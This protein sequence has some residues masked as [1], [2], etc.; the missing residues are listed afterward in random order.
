M[1]PIKLSTKSNSLNSIVIWYLLLWR[2]IR[3]QK[4]VSLGIHRTH[5]V[6]N[7]ETKAQKIL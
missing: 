2:I 5:P 6:E 4:I 7:S 3:I 1:T